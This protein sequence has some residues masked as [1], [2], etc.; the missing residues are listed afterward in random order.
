MEHHASSP[1]F[2]LYGYGVRNTDCKCGERWRNQNKALSDWLLKSRKKIVILYNEF[3]S[4]ME[5]RIRKERQEDY[6][7]I[8]ELV[9]EAFSNSE[10]SDGD[11]H[12][13]IERIR[14]SSD[15]IPELS[16]VAVSGNIVIG[17]IMFSTI[18]VGQ[19]EAISLAPLAVSADWQRKGVG[20]L[21]VSE[22]HRQAHKMGY[23]CSVVLGD[24]DYYSK[25]GYE[26]ASNHGIIAPFDVP[27]DYY[28]VCGLDKNCYIPKGCVKYSDAF[29]I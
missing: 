4:D 11:E 2:I 5:I 13:L 10:R 22:G 7:Q 3:N 15:Y 16:L 9:K 25:F 26:K 24:S 6:Q 12:N 18:S 23:S 19:S 17:H 29:G 1:Y 27:D 28:M 14:H 8:R 21:L 20:K